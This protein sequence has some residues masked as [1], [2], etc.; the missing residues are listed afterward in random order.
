MAR[1]AGVL[2]L[3]V[4]SWGSVFAGVWLLLLGRITLTGELDDITALVAGV[5]IAIA[6]STSFWLD[7]LK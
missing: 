5:I 2:F 3:F 6:L 7:G 1:K 4:L